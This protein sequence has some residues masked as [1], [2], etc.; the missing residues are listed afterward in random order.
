MKRPT[1]PR[2]SPALWAGVVTLVAL[3]AGFPLALAAKQGAVGATLQVA[4]LLPFAVVGV[5]VAAKQPRNP[6]GF[7]L[8]GLGLASAALTDGGLY[9]VLRY[10]EGYGRLPLGRVAVALTPYGFDDVL[11]ILPLVVLLFPDGHLPSRRWRPA[12]WGYFAVWSVVLGASVVNDARAFTD[13]RLVIDSSG[14]LKTFDH[15]SGLYATVTGIATPLYGLFGLS[16]VVAQVLAYR[17][18]R[19]ERRA[20]LKWLLA[21]GAFAIAGLTFVI[22]LGSSGSAL[23]EITSFVGFI[24]IVALPIAIG[25]GIL[26]YRL[27]DIDRLI[28]RTVSYTLLTVALLAVFAA[29][30]LVATRV[31]PISSS[32]AVA[33]S[34]LAVAALFA[35]LRARLQRLVDRRFN[36]AGYDV[37]AIVS[38]FSARLRNTVDL[39]SVNAELVAAVARA[40]EPSHLS[41]WIRPDRAVHERRSAL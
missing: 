22:S 33:A 25:V 30:V 5:V 6:V 13:S 34:T 39:E 32:P 26:K 27:Y 8:V 40:I 18:A 17:R 23:L 36:R 29:L 41:L 16:F 11:L 38:G 3:A 28:S 31:L 7:L 21:G 19:G 2:S 10:H 14:Q 35:P 15:S 24:A 37:E 1:G 12:L 20:Q 4:I 9:A